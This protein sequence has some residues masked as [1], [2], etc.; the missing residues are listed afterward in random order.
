MIHVAKKYGVRPA[1]THPSDNLLKALPIWYHFALVQERTSANTRSNKCLRERHG[2][3]TVADCLKMAERPEDETAHREN[4]NCVCERCSREKEATGCE[5][6]SSCMK[7]ARNI[8]SKLQEKWRPGAGRNEDGLSLTR[9]QWEENAR[10]M[11]SKDTVIF[12]PSVTQDAPAANVFRAFVEATAADGP[13]A[14][15]PARPF[16]IVEEATDV[17]TDGSCDRN[18]AENARAGVGVWFAGD[19]ARNCAARVP[20]DCQTNQA[21]EAYAC[22][23][24]A[25]RTPDYAPLTIITDSM[26]VYKGLT[27]HLKGWEDRGWLGVSNSNILKRV[28]A[29]LRRRSAVTSFKWVKGHSGVLGNE[30][31]DR[32]AARGATMA[33]TQL[34]PLTELDEGFLPR[35]V[36][37]T[38]LT[39]KLAYE[40]ILNWKGRTAREKTRISLEMTKCALQEDYGV[41]LD[42]GAIWKNIWGKEMSVK[43]SCF[44]WRATHQAYKV[45]AYWN[46]ISGYEARG[47]CGVCGVEESMSHIMM[48][49]TAPG[50]TVLWG[51]AR[52]VRQ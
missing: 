38:T 32:L 1:A 45:G 41:W 35:G 30:G 42:E 12:D 50:Q 49:C 2:V 10:R 18:G 16:Q 39:Q 20:G 43:V 27:T 51:L 3:K 47:T 5:N 22:I 46:N 4:K 6:P 37:L 19:D 21:A 13:R 28:A 26:Y 23:V 36:N 8:L 25:E 9:D 24:A 29:R 7:A 14:T 33:P 44:F 31:A 11:E 52:A 34:P 40:A 48:E 15:R 17:H